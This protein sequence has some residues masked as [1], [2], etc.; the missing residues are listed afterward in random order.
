MTVDPE[1]FSAALD[2]LGTGL[3]IT[4]AD[5]TVVAANQATRDLL[6]DATTGKTV[7]DTVAAAMTGSDTDRWS[8]RPGLVAE[9]SWSE[10]L[11]GTAHEGRCLVLR[12]V[13]HRLADRARLR[14]QST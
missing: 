4:S 5:G 6:E 10:L 7:G 13:S 9:W 12:D 8:P 1:L 11:P 14:R 2:Q 3:L